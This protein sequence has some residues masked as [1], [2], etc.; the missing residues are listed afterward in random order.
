MGRSPRWSAEHDGYRSL[1]P[2]VAPPPIGATGRA[3]FGGSR[4]STASRRREDIP[5]GWRSTWAP[6]S[7]PGWSETA[8]ISPGQSGTSTRSATLSLPDG[9]SWSLS[10]GATDPILGWYSP[11]FGEKQPAWAVVGEGACSR[12]GLDTYTTV[13]QFHSMT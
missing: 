2:P 11:R 9:L 4:S 3:D 6:T 10:R 1:D 12:T 8:S 5:S 7:K 13:L